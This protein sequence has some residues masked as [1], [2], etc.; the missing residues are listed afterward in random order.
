M[1]AR[2]LALY[3]TPADPETFDRYYRQIT[4]RS[5]ATCR[6]CA[7]KRLAVTSR[8]CTA[9]SATC[10]TPPGTRPGTQN[11]LHRGR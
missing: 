7:S 5:C 10:G 1:T 9:R 6:G 4:F 8:P 2:F 3:E 11:D